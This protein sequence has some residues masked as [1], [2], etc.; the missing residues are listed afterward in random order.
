MATVLGLYNGAL[1]LLKAARLSTVSDARE[2]R[3]AL[4]QVYDSVLGY[5]LESGD[6][7]FAART[8]ALED[9]TD[10]EPEF[11]FTYSFE[12]PS[13]VVRLIAIS[14]TGDLWPPLERFLEEGGMWHADC[15]RAAAR[16][17]VD[18]LVAIGGPAADGLVDGAREAGL[19]ARRIMRF[20]DSLSAAEPVAVLVRSG[21][22]VLVKGSRGTRTDIV[23]DR[24]K[25]V[26]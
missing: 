3:Y 10:V 24:L 15:G 7:N 18:I 5:C 13:D 21:D 20:A 16:A 23:A 8:V 6:W 1:F 19:D 2:E 4:D 22:V 11:G 14:S 25:A 9:D 12:K 26:A 17:G